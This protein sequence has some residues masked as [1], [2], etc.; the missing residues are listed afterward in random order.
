MST[1]IIC[2]QKEILK[3]LKLQ[4]PTKFVAMYQSDKLAQ[5]KRA[6]LLELVQINYKKNQHDDRIA[7]QCRF[8]VYCM[9]AKTALHDPYALTDFA[10]RTGLLIQEKGVWGF[11]DWVAQPHDIHVEPHHLPY[12]EDSFWTFKVAWEQDIYLSES[13]W[14]QTEEF[15]PQELCMRPGKYVPYSPT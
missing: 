9:S 14:S 4:F 7:A 10:T 8:H 15:Q 12:Y 3:Q 11:P 5:A 2:V 1:P 6:C 13:Y